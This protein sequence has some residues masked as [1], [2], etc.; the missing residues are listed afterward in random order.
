[1]KVPQNLLRQLEQDKQVENQ[2][3]LGGA[4]HRALHVACEIVCSLALQPK[5]LKLRDKGEVEVRKRQPDA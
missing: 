1:M 2:R 3:D 4:A 5:G